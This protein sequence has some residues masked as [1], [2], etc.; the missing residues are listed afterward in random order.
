VDSPDTS[1]PEISNSPLRSPGYQHGS[2]SI[3]AVPSIISQPRVQ[4][5]ASVISVYPLNLKLFS[6][7]FGPNNAHFMQPNCSVALYQEYF[8]IKLS[9]E[10]F[11]RTSIDIWKDTIE[12]IQYSSEID[13]ATR[14]PL[15]VF[16]ANV[17]QYLTR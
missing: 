7:S 3:P 13:S 16:K 12:D 4:P 10:G 9:K 8:K 5:N 2:A 11:D 14:S 6:I 17:G 15:L 1:T